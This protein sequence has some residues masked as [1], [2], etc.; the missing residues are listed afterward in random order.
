[1]DDSMTPETARVYRQALTYAIDER[2]A[3]YAACI[4]FASWHAQLGQILWAADLDQSWQDWC[5][6]PEAVQVFGEVDGEVE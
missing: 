5:Q 2:R 4:V 6:R 1:V 3:P